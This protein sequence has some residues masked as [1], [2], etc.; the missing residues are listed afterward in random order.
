MI[1]T[2]LI[3]SINQ[4]LERIRQLRQIIQGQYPRE[5]DGLRQVCL[6]RLDAAQAD[7]KRLAQE[8][9]V[10]KGLQTPRRIREFKRVVEHLNAVEGVGVFALKRT[11]AEDHVLNFL[12]TELCQEIRYP[13][14]PPV[15][16]QMSQ[17][18]FHIYPEFNLLCVPLIEGR[19]LLHLPD[20]Y[21]EL[22]HPFHRAQHT[23]LPTLEAY[24][25]CFKNS[26]FAMVEHFQIEAVAADRLRKPEGKRFQIQLWKTCWVK[27]WMEELY[28]DLFG[29]LT[30]GP[31][32]VWSHYHLC[33]KRGGNPFETPL[34]FAA[35]HPAD[36]A[37]MKAMLKMLAQMDGYDPEAGS[38][39]DAWSDF[40]QTMSFRQE[41]EYRQCYSDDLL[42]VIVKEAKSGVEKVGIETAGKDSPTMIVSLLND[43]WREFWKNPQRY[44]S[45][46]GQKLACL[47]KSIAKT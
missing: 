18:Y 11:S 12:I 14:V 45:W 30:A 2:Y 8:P 15:I 20:I 41:P 27:Y 25:A 23:D 21:H 34:T 9:V 26:L 38:I 37:R 13:L 1:E 5:Y 4:S 44:Q 19:F 43:A 29:V 31:A 32:F 6:T 35:T 17:D 47:Q 10:D 28:C 22:C 39:R 24:H 36:D 40:L 3:G 33:I 16:S 46:E 7:L 42:S